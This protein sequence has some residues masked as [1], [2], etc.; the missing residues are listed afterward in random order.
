[1]KPRVYLLLLL[2]TLV[3]AC[4][5]TGKRP[6]LVYGL[7]GRDLQRIGNRLGFKVEKSVAGERATHVMIVKK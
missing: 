7:S 6:E 5:T 4:A 1:M 3:S 2:A